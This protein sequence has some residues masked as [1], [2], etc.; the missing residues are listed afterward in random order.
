V[1]I[2]GVIGNLDSQFC[3]R[4]KLSLMPNN[5]FPLEL[6]YG[7]RALFWNDTFIVVANNLFG[8]GFLAIS[9]DA[10][11][12]WW[13]VSQQNMKGLKG[14]TF[15]DAVGSLN[16]PNDFIIITAG[17][18]FRTKDGA[19]TFTEAIGATSYYWGNVYWQLPLLARD[20]TLVNTRYAI[21]W[22][23]GFFRTDDG[24]DNWHQSNDNRWPSRDGVLAVDQARS[25]SVWV[26][27]W[28]LTVTGKA[29]W[30]STDGGK[31]WDLVGNFSVVDLTSTGTYNGIDHPAIDVYDGHV[32]VAANGP[33]DPGLGYSIYSSPDD[34]K[35]WTT[36]T[37]STYHL[38]NVI[39]LGVDPRNK[40]RV[41]ATF[42][43]HSA[44][45]W[46]P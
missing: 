29:L 39:S 20:P 1:D 22:G 44:A 28:T 26:V 24:G 37:S 16:D 7:H 15:V 38:S 9:Q 36:L 45:A 33:A 23:T 32:V 35:T 21:L 30:H 25:E 27:L 4:S 31:T 17:G 18:M 34:G 11:N 19:K 46:I 41:Y 14:S 8:E 43:G 5:S 13:E 2:I 42:D 12:V 6:R 10:G 3:L 40:G